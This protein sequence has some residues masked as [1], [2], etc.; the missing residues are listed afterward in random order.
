[1][2]GGAFCAVDVVEVPVCARPLFGSGSPF[3]VTVGV[4]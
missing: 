4:L 2:E 3:T 1:M